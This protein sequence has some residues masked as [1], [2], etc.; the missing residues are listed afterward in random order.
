MED[1]NK[2]KLIFKSSLANFGGCHKDAKNTKELIR[3]VAY[4]P[5]ATSWQINHV[6]KKKKTISDNGI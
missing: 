5:F 2:Y 4:R 3:L 1:L 6:Y